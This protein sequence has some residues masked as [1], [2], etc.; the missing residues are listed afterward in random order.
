MAFRIPDSEA[1]KLDGIGLGMARAQQIS[2]GDWRDDD[3]ERWLTDHPLPADFVW[4]GMRVY[5]RK[6]LLTGYGQWLRTAGS[7][8]APLRGLFRLCC[9]VIIGL[10]VGQPMPEPKDLAL[11][12]VAEAKRR[13]AANPT[14]NPAET[15]RE[16][17]GNPGPTDDEPAY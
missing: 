11:M 13:G 3:V 5:P 1:A 7:Y 6:Q 10:P 16:P 4:N 17:T 15:Q 2:T 12:L 8:N 9:D 14:G